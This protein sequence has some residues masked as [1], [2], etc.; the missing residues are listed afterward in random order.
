MDD[1]LERSLAAAT[2][3]VMP[4]TLPDALRDRP[5]TPTMAT[6]WGLTKPQVYAL[7]LT[8]PARG[9]WSSAACES[10]V[11]KCS[12]VGL[13]VQRHAFSHL[14]AARIHGLPL[15]MSLDD[16]VAIHVTRNMKDGAVRRPGFVGHRGLSDR[17]V[18][19]VAG[20]PVTSLADTWVD[21]GELVRPGI[22]LGHDDL[23]MI[24]DAVAAR[25]GSVE[26]LRT[27]LAARVA[28][29]GKLTLLEAL[30]WVRVGSESPGETRT[31]LVLVRAGL[32][33]PELNKPAYAD[34][35]RWLGRPDMRWVDQRVLL[36]YQGREF[37][38]SP[39]QRQHDEARFQRFSDG[40]WSV[41]EVWD[42]DV[43]SDAAR[44]AL[45]L[46][47]ANELGHPRA[48]LDLSA[49][50]PRFFSQ[51][52]LELADIRARRLRARANAA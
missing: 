13:V 43:H 32:P 24:G 16:D 6:A 1:V 36:E 11:E 30:E 48:A 45:V 41:I 10:L 31:R 49:I 47:A 46:R 4:A 27:A 23:V 7:N 15:P 12:A 25:L 20:L 33:E 28:P 29:R 39:E 22:P 52:M 44:Y 5:F 40:G 21:L 34:D 19:R 37:H 35:R 18:V 38:D 50:H 14:T 2:I 26:P 9:V 17:T 42:D 8:S 3:V 51:R